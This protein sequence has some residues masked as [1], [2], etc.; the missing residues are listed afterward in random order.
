MTLWKRHGLVF[1]A[2]MLCVAV[3]AQGIGPL[4]YTGVALLAAGT[5]LRW[6]LV[7]TQRPP[8]DRRP[9][10]VRMPATGRWTA[11]NGPATK[12]PS[13]THSHA[14]TYAIDLKYD[15]P[16]DE[17]DTPPTPP[18][19]SW[20]PVV[21]RPRSYPSFGRPLL[22]PAAGVVVA[23]ASRQRDHLSRMSLPGLAFLYLESF[24]RSLGWPCHLL[25]NY[26]VLDIGDGVYA[27]YA[28][29]RRGSLR[30]GV[31]DRVAA[32]Q[33][34]AECGNSGNSSEPHLH[35]QL[36]D[37][38]DVMTAR[39][40]PFEWHYRDDDGDE[41]RGV[42]K[43]LTHFSPGRPVG[44]REAGTCSATGQEGRA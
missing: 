2:G 24:V 40:V 44:V 8:R 42:P 29:L 22:A 9:V 18:A 38:P 7:R 33:E 1:G 27:V 15:P 36:M 16:Q 35:F 19:H 10:L 30:V 43:D 20:W 12:V 28:H 3:N 41:H 39:G 11:L 5:L 13:H 37:G 32:G 23:A 34:I 6:A 25:G 17:A 21:R 31:G 14:Q 26:L 4:W